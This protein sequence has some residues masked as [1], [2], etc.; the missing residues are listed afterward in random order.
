MPH[1]TLPTG[2]DVYY[3]I[4]G[5]GEPLLLIMGTAADHTTWAAQVEA[6]RDSYSVITYDARGTGQSSQPERIED[7]SMRILADD[8]AALLTH[9]GVGRAHVSGLS[10]GSATAQE[11]A[12]DLNCPNNFDDGQPNLRR[13]SYPNQP[14]AGVIVYE[15][16]N[17][18]ARLSTVL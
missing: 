2:V 12:E 4:E 11:L 15:T 7:Y 14:V 13:L 8:A 17:R 10:L 1:V 16:S 9:L 6:Y 5:S 18:F 3:E